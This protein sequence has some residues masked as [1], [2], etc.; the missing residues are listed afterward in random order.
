MRRAILA[1]SQEPALINR[2]L[3]PSLRSKIINTGAD[4]F[5]PAI[6]NLK[7]IEGLK[8]RNLITLA[9]GCR[10][11]LTEDGRALRTFLRAERDIEDTEAA[12]MVTAIPPRLIDAI[13]RRTQ[14]DTLRVV[15]RAF[16]TRHG[17]IP[18]GISPRLDIAAEEM[19]VTA[20]WKARERP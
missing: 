11:Q 10:W 3:S 16:V 6:T 19:G 8:R 7:S 18:A 2:T 12:V 5:L 15:E 17:V 9:D 14:Y 4:G 20:Q 13:V 1:P